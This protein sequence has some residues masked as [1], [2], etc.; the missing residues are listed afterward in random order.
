MAQLGSAPKPCERG[1]KPEHPS[2]PPLA[3][4]VLGMLLFASV[5]IPGQQNEAGKGLGRVTAPTANMCLLEKVFSHCSEGRGQG[6][7][8]THTKSVSAV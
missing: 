5:Y 8:R 6:H 7:R 2:A 3:A 4:P 1:T